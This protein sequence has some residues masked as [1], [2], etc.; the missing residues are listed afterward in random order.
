[1]TEFNVEKLISDYL[2]SVYVISHSQASVDSYKSSIDHF[3]KFIQS[4]YEKPL[5]QILSLMK[6][7]SIDRYKIFQEFVIYHY[8]FI[9]VR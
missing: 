4:K 6:D 3:S 2:D 9:I 7:E 5:D 8:L 1:M